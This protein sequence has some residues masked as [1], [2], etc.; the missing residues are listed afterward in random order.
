MANRALVNTSPN[1]TPSYKDL[2]A[3]EAPQNVY[4]NEIVIDV[5][6]TATIGSNDSDIFYIPPDSGY[7]E[8]LLIGGGGA[9]GSNK[10]GAGLGNYSGGGGAGGVIHGIY[11]VNSYLSS[12]MTAIVGAGGTAITPSGSNGASDHNG[13]VG[14]NSSLAS[15]GVSPV[16][17]A[18]AGGGGGGGAGDKAA[19]TRTATD[20]TG[21]GGGLGT[22]SG[23]GISGGAG[24]GAGSRAA[25]F[26]DTAGAF[27]A[28]SWGTNGVGHVGAVVSTVQNP[29]I[30]ISVMGREVAGGGYAGSGTAVGHRAMPRNF[31]SGAGGTV[32]GNPSLAERSGLNGTGGGGSG[33]S[34]TL[35]ADAQGGTGGSGLLVIRYPA[36]RPALGKIQA[37]TWRVAPETNNA[38][39]GGSIARFRGV[40][41]NGGTMVAIG[42]NATHAR[43][44]DGGRTWSHVNV[45]SVD[46][47]E[48]NSIAFGGG[49]FVAGKALG[50][51]YSSDGSSW[52]EQALANG[53]LG[54]NG[55]EAIAY[56]DGR[57]V[58]VGGGSPS[59]RIATSE[60][61]TT[62]TNRV[63]SAGTITGTPYFNNVRYLNSRFIACGNASFNRLLSS[64][65][66]LGSAGTLWTSVGTGITGAVLDVA[67]D[68]RNYLVLTET[69]LY[70]SRTLE[71]S[72]YT[73]ITPTGWTGTPTAFGIASHN[74]VTVLALNGNDDASIG[75]AYVS[76][77][78]EKTSS[79]WSPRTH[80]LSRWAYNGSVFRNSQLSH[81]GDRIEYINNAFV[82][83]GRRGIISICRD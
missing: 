30:G 52:T 81:P 46:G 60:N 71:N 61:G 62:W 49:L 43:S 79:G 36:I 80:G 59:Y 16:T 53:I 17:I 35:S 74:G 39:D 19:A 65:S 67:W 72:S 23:D 11:N 9:G 75:R 6:G 57:F 29:G 68:G 37:R 41:A 63:T 10:A 48:R 66:Y 33:A 34:G 28:Q 2:F 24:G 44:V 70:K 38:Y 42:G 4:F 3:P 77:D 21:S 14:G 50:I 55:P 20:S 56:G 54:A 1:S 78:A 13:G 47:T 5:A 12:G 7:I 69:A 83:V 51:S 25:W 31:G 27:A 73:L 58:G 45:G 40:A 32:A 82:I 8:L 76:T 18:I 22:I 26:S 15:S 64:I